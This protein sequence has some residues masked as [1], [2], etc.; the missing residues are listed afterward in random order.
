MKKCKQCGRTTGED[1][2][3]CC[4]ACEVDWLLH[5]AAKR[6]GDKE[7]ACSQCQD[8]IARQSERRSG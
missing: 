5:D 6:H 2:D 7:C 3:F 1:R 8:R 4:G